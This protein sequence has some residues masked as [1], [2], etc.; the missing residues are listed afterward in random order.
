M[1]LLGIVM[2]YNEEDCIE[3]AVRSLLDAG[4]QVH[5]INHGSTDSTR[6]RVLGFRPVYL[7]PVRPPKQRAVRL[8]D[9]SRREVPF[10]QLFK[11]TSLYVRRQAPFFD[12]V[13]WQ[14]ADELIRPPSHEPLRQEHIEAEYEKGIRVISPM[15]LEFWPS[16]AD[17][18]EEKVPDYLERIRHY[19]PRPRP[20]C[21]RSWELKRTGNMPHGLHR[22]GPE[23]GDRSILSRNDWFLY[24]HPIR[25]AKQGRRKI[26]QER[27][28]QTLHYQR[29]AREGC[30]NLVRDAAKLQ[31]RDSLVFL[32]GG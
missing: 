11:W 25:S 10:L 3:R 31:S 24:H 12:W 6:A 7:A 1:R 32:G 2:A 29:Y 18:S 26:M 9:V 19:R 23:W 13:T 21:P 16:T 14:A 5:V 28:K 8:I 30:R 17:E 22:P 4:H 20:N 27:P 15:L